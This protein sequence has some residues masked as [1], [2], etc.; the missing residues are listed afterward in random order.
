MANKKFWLGMLV[1]VLV[2]GMT[3]IG[4]DRTKGGGTWVRVG[5]DPQG[6][7]VSIMLWI[8]SDGWRFDGGLGEVRGSTIRWSGNMGELIQDNGQTFANIV[9]LNRNSMNL[10]DARRPITHT[11]TRSR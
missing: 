6:N 10:S 2:F 3:V 5:T 1:I 8:T 7:I 9:L 4:C 11:L